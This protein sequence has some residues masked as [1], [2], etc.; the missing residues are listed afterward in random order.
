MVWVDVCRFEPAN[1][2]NL[3][4]QFPRIETLEIP[5][6][7]IEDEQETLLVASKV[8]E[9][10]TT[11]DDQRSRESSKQVTA[12]V[13]IAFCEKRN[14]KKN[15]IMPSFGGKDDDF[16]EEWILDVTVLRS[17][18]SEIEQINQKAA[19]KKALESILL[20]ISVETNKQRDHMPAIVTPDPFVMCVSH[21]LSSQGSTW[22]NLLSFVPNS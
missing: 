14:A 2:L 4:I 10:L 9:I 1:S 11:I 16:W 20:K 22:R 12:Q 17:I 5:Y 18:T 7:K 13:L 6:C 3:R 19:L 15:W 8:D 21:K